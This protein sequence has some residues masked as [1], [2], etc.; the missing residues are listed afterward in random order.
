M[1]N[2]EMSLK[3]LIDAGLDQYRDIIEEVSK[4]AEK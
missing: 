3:V 2:E 1:P 4:R